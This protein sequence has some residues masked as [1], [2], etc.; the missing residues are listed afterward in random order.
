VKPPRYAVGYL[1]SLGGG[2]SRQAGRPAGE[3]SETDLAFAVSV[4]ISRRA[5]R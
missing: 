5:R 2:A 4:G 3:Q 1:R